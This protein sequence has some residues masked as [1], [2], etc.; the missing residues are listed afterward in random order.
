MWNYECVCVCVHA[1]M[2]TQKC[3]CMQTCSNTNSSPWRRERATCDSCW[4]TS[5]S[6]AECR[7]QREQ[8]PPS[9]PPSPCPASRPPSTRWQCPATAATTTARGR[10]LRRRWELRKCSVWW[11]ELVWSC[12]RSHHGNRWRLTRSGWK[13]WWLGGQLRRKM[14]RRGGRASPLLSRVLVAGE[15]LGRQYF[16]WHPA[17]L[18]TNS[19][20]SDVCSA[21]QMQI[22]PKDR[23][24][25]KS[26][27]IHFYVLLCFILFCSILS[28][29]HAFTFTFLLFWPVQV[30]SVGLSEPQD[31]SLFYTVI[32]NNKVLLTLN[33]NW[34]LLQ[35]FAFYKW[36][37]DT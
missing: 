8:S 9:T 22:K 14:W 13:G 3:T 33:M 20:M 2:C 7:C 21:S 29:L 1:C 24:G 12:W 5:S 25:T 16:Q 11:G 30:I 27:P 6:W 15:R 18:F 31:A 36:C 35:T 4:R 23:T 10:P 28:D 37:E 17:S 26:L 19:Q 32:M 34:I